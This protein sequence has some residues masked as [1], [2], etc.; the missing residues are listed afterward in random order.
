[1]PSEIEVVL[2]RQ[3]T[4]SQFRTEDSL[5]EE[6]QLEL[7][8]VQ[9]EIDSK[10]KLT[11]SIFDLLPFQADAEKSI[12]IILT[13]LLNSSSLRLIE[14]VPINETSFLS[15][16]DED[17]LFDL[18]SS[19][20]DSISEEEFNFEDDALEDIPYSDNGEDFSPPGELI[21]L[22]FLSMKIL[23]ATHLCLLLKT[24]L[25]PH[26]TIPLNCKA[27]HLVFMNFSIIYTLLN[28]SIL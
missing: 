4:L 27:A 10:N 6:L 8:N 13:N 7:F 5:L 22:N 3:S 17:S 15:D 25:F 11:S 12:P 23:L 19:L 18:D 14:I 28:S 9:S 26:F 16:S 2:N 20:D 1:M 21:I 24:A